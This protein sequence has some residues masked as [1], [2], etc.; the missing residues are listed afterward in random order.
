[1]KNIWLLF[2]LI[3]STTLTPISVSLCQTSGNI[4]LARQYNIII[5]NETKNAPGNVMAMAQSHDGNLW[6]GSEN[7]IS[8][9]D[10]L[11]F[12]SF[13]RQNVKELSEDDCSSIL[14]ARDSSIYFG[15]Y[16]GIL[17]QFRNEH[18]TALGSGET[19]HGKTITA[20]C[21]DDSGSIWIVTDGNG[22]FRY[23]QGKFTPLTVKDG[24]PSSAINTIAKGN[25]EEIW[26]GTDEGLSRI[27]GGNITHFT[28]KNGLPSSH[29]VTA[30]FTD[31]DQRLWIGDASGKLC[32]Y[33]HGKFSPMLPMHSGFT[34]KINVITDDKEGNLWI[35]TEGNGIIIFLKNLQLFTKITMKE[36][37]SADIVKCII[38]NQEG[39]MLVGTQGNGL[40]RLRK[41][42][43][44]TYEKV[45]GLSENM[46]MCLFKAKDQSVW[47]SYQNGCINRYQNGRFED[48]SSYF[49][50]DGLPVFSIT[51][52][53]NNTFW[54][55]TIGKLIRFDGHKT[56]FFNP[57]ID[58]GNTLFHAL[59]TG[60]DGA[61]WA[62]TDAGIYIIQGEKVTTLT[63]KDGLSDGRIF[64]FLED[65]FGKMWIGTQEGGIN[66]FDHGKITQITTEDGLSDNLILSIYEDSGGS[67]WVGTGHNGLNHID[68]KT[69]KIVF[70]GDAIGSPRM[71][72]FITEDKNGTMWFGTEDGILAA[73]K[74]D[75]ELFIDGK[76]GK[77]NVRGFGT[78]E[79]M[80]SMVCMGGVFPSGCITPDGHIWIPTTAGIVSVEPSFAWIQPIDSKIAV[81]DLILNNKSFGKTSTYILPAGGV[82]VEIKY[83]APSFISPEKQ[84]YRYKLEGYDREWINAGTRRE[85]YY[86]KLPPGNYNFRVQVCNHLGLWSEKEALVSIHV[87]PFFY[88]TIWF[89]VACIIIVISV[90]YLFLKYRIRQIREKELELLVVERTEEIRKLNEDLE[91]K[92]ADRTAQLA[93]SNTEL[94]A[95]SYSVSHDLKAPVRRIEGLIL[96]LTEDYADKLDTTARDFLQKISESIENMGQLIDELLKLSRI[97]RQELERMEV[98]LSGMAQR[99]CDQLGKANPGRNIK[100]TIQPDIIIDCDARLVQIAL[101]NLFDN[102]WKYS[103]KNPQSAIEF[104][105]IQKDDKQ[106]LFIHDN[107][108]GFDMGHYNKLFT[109]FQRLHSPDQFSGTG[110]GL[111]T[112]KRIVIKHGGSIWAE[113]EPDKGT[114]FYFNF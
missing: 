62:G 21:E 93:A 12:R 72:T 18:F 4:E 76:S 70:L 65:H 83:S 68:G 101:Q 99:I 87:K 64:C 6:M 30:L 51:E 92:V 104:G 42:I 1:M 8:C 43:L 29:G 31:P 23:K 94:E 57:G 3:I 88:Q 44:R 24:V 79:G 58:L 106:L 7:G 35:G 56:S 73:E 90:F 80:V 84:I 111:A 47:I 13:T 109:P 49:K 28:T 86:T 97:A 41:N 98:N 14:V 16:G 105:C 100:I 19:F 32:F 78:P 11:S 60:T 69:G 37:L 5:W 10:G 20:L 77:I 53:K 48:L 81:E 46:V 33:D 17:V 39:D 2:G 55:A 110:I 45:D 54:V 50:I 66:I 89:I 9:F 113:S 103:A 38:R 22:L 112:V 26:L 61:V 63:K 15:L 91:Q 59:Y 114:T 27:K 85:A 67:V 52:D 74:K 95:F 25:G 107:G 40:N 108:V 82:H 96:A 75:L 34:E 71:V 36:G 102:A